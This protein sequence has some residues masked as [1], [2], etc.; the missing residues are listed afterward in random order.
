MSLF[1]DFIFNSRSRLK[2]IKGMKTE[3]KDKNLVSFHQMIK[4]IPLNGFPEVYL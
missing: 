4:N 1:L 2:E 3:S